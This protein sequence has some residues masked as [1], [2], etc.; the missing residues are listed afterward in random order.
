MSVCLSVCR[1]PADVDDINQLPVF[2][3]SI[4]FSRV[5][6]LVRISFCIQ[7]TK[8]SVSG[9]YIR[10]PRFPTTPE[11]DLSHHHHHQ[12]SRTDEF[13]PYSIQSPPPLPPVK[14]PLSLVARKSRTDMVVDAS[15]SHSTGLEPPK[16]GWIALV[17]IHPGRFEANEC[18]QCYTVIHTYFG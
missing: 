11:C 13:S 4:W 10:S 1:S 14:P 9:I 3:S 17:D 18:L 12:V 8:H 6:F 15:H 5:L 2:L 7:S 16:T